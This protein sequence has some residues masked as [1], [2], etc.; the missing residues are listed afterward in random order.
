VKD[1]EIS[2]STDRLGI[3]AFEGDWDLDDLSIKSS[4]RPVLQLLHDA[5]GVPFV[6]RRI[7]T[8]EE[9]DYYV[10]K[11]LD[12]NHTNYL[13]GY[14][15]FHGWKGAICPGGGDIDLEQ[16][17]ALIGPHAHGRMLHFSTCETLAV[18]KAELQ[19]LLKQT[20]ARTVS[21]YTGSV[22]WI[23]SAAFDL[24]V[25]EA[26]AEYTYPKAAGN[27]LL[28]RYKALSDRLGLVFESR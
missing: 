3:F 20:K 23:E 1:S 17:A 26:L 25:L 13:I 24:I 15:A 28:R 9:L 7:G 2:E 11:W 22:D 21:G 6:H 19:R 27:M 4:I 18:P 12:E 8:E 16:L 5:C 10:D 14:F